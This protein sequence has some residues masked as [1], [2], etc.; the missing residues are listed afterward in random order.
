MTVDGAIHEAI[1][2]SQGSQVFVE[3]VSGAV[4]EDEETAILYKENKGN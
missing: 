3:I 2:A 1:D 4:E